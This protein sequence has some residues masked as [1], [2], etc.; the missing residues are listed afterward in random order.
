[1]GVLKWYSEADTTITNAYKADL[2]SRGETGNMGI[3]DALEVF[4]LHGQAAKSGTASKEFARILIRF[5]V[6]K[7]RDSLVAEDVPLPSA[8]N[9]PK[10]IL[11]MFNAPHPETLLGILR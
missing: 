9:K 3:A 8:T 4:V 10:Y 6:E 1:M 5:N 2:S 11:R 7:I